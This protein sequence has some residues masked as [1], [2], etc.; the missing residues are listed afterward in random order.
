MR[1]FGEVCMA[2]IIVASTMVGNGIL[3]GF[4]LWRGWCARLQWFTVMT[5]LAVPL[6][7]IFN[8]VHGALHHLYGPARIFV[9]YLWGPIIMG[10]CAWEAHRI[11][12]NWL[13]RLMLMQFSLTLM[14]L[15]A[16]LHGEP[17]AVYQMEMNFLCWFNLAGILFSIWK[18]KGN[19]RMSHEKKPL[20]DAPVPADEQGEDEGGGPAIPP[21]PPN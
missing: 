1:P 12:V 4:L 15:F 6:D 13:E 9:V 18:L 5:V 20:H 3:I 14:C 10:L 2:D 21:D 19:A 17:W 8:Y 7:G 11:K 16:H